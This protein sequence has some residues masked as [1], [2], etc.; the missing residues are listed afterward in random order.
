MEPTAEGVSVFLEKYCLQ[1]HGEGKV[2]GKVDF[3]TVSA[4]RPTD[5]DFDL[6]ELASEV[7]DYEEM[8]PEE[9]KQ[10]TVEERAAFLQWYRNVYEKVEA[11]P[12][13][14]QPRRLSAPEYRNTM[15]SVF[16]FDL[17]NKVIA[18]EQTVTEPSLILK[19]M[20]TDPPGESGY[21]NDTHAASLSTHLWDQYAY[22]SEAAVN[23]LFARVRRPQLEDLVGKELPGDFT[24]TS[25]TQ[26][27]AAALLENFA[28]R[29]FRRPI[30]EEMLKEKLEKIAGLSGNRLLR[31]VKFEMRAVL[32]SPAFFYRGMMM[33]QSPGKQQS[34]DSYELAE[35]LSYFFWED[36]PDEELSRVASDGSLNEPEVFQA[37]VLR[38]LESPRARSLAESFAVQWLV[39]DE[40]DDV[41]ADPTQLHAFKNQ[42]IDFLNYLFTENRPVMEIIDSEVTFA[43]YITASIYPKDRHQLAKYVKPKGIE[44]A[45][46]P[47]QKIRLEKTEGRGGLLTMPAIL[48]MNHGPIIRGTWTLRH[49]LGEHLGEPPADIPPIE[50]TAGDRSLSFREKFARHR[51][52]AACARC[53]DKIDPL[54]FAF[55][56]YNDKGGFLLGR[57]KKALPK[58]VSGKSSSGNQIDPSGK[59]PTGETFADFEEL[60]QILMTS[61]R[62]DIVRNIVE[63]VLS[64]ALCRDLEAYDA[65][66]VESITETIVNSNGS[67]QDLFLEVVN[68]LPFRETVFPE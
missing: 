22:F 60:K 18:A 38:L 23:Q 57:D 44:R 2:K 61:R 32:M 49:I 26:T 48:A 24:P 35:R 1:C 5:G 64:Y 65:P 8:P 21:I 13:V 66:A 28:N 16:G 68:S 29:A 40:I 51:S 20:P 36:M 10:P 39:L 11:K 67:W 27:Q 6:W 30:P 50:S 43:N 42:P 63:Q 54:G 45:S 7:V 37:Q 53:H 55:E 12:G 34:V 9:E 17:E 3:T 4:S 31:A 56:A 15:R 52:D 58:L 59:L 25:L 33:P 19:L 41:Y 14:F 46:V 47:N 62:E